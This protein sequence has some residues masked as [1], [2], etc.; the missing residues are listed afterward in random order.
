[1]NT[2]KYFIISALFYI[3]LLIFV[4]FSKKR[5]K[6]KENKIYSFLIVTSFVGVLLEIGCRITIPIMDVYPITNYIITKLYLVYLLLWVTLL[7]SYTYVVIS[8]IEDFKREN[9]KIFKILMTISYLISTF[10][11]FLFPTYYYDDGNLI[12]TYGPSVYYVYIISF[13][14]V[15]II[16]IILFF[17]K[18]AFKSRK[19]L[20]IMS[21]ISIGT[22]TTV[23]Q[24]A[25]PGMLLV[26]SMETFITVLMY[27]TIE[28][29]DLKMVEEV[30]KA[31]EI[32][33]N[34][35]EEKTMFLYNMTNEIRGITMD[36]NK[37]AD[38][39]L[40]ETDNKKINVEVIDNSAREIKGSTARFRTL[41]NEVLDISNVDTASTK[42]YNNKY[43]IKVLLKQI[44]KI[45][46][47][48][49]KEKG[50]DFRVSIDS[51]IPEYLY[52]DS[53]GLKKV[54]TIIL[55]NSIKHTTNGYIE[56]SINAIIK[57][58]I[59]R[60]IISVEDSGIGIKV[61]DINKMFTK[62][63]SEKEEND[64]YTV[65]KILTLMNGTIVTNST[66]KKGTIMKVIL[67]QRFDIEKGKLSQYEKKYNKKRVL[68]I[69]EDNAII[70]L[71]TKNLENMEIK[72]DVERLGK[73]GLDK[74]RSKEK[75]DLIILDEKLE[76]L[77]GFVIM[78]KLRQIRNFKTNVILITEDSNYRYQDE[79]F[80]DY[81]VKPIKKDIFIDKIRKYLS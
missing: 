69:E 10:L 29:P 51:D 41:T 64:L 23:I 74:I 80:I 70:K 30:H 40:D 34:A 27:F 16:I 6:I 20:P 49:I 65:K 19:M 28:N 63:N 32:S 12:Y 18:K 81:V 17:S 58:N 50:L 55:D 45:Y 1:M 7:T 42:V 31:K 46:Q 21:L 4:Y 78:Y 59:A 54:L 3:I 60:L 66:Y 38:I 13:I 35:N 26:T 43:N 75:Y 37:E 33:D 24:F 72:V 14:Y 36:I 73:D 68:L 44:V 52:G 15:I 47:E 76:P 62:I 56:V 9:K 67:D 5:F 25:N 48:R 39:I 71:I 22:V 61:D 77:N 11:I 8:D 2:G 53:I 79:G 57:N